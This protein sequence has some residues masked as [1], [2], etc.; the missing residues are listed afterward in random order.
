MTVCDTVAESDLPDRTGAAGVIAEAAVSR[1]TAKYVAI[2][3]KHFVLLS[4][5]RNYGPFCAERH[6]SLSRKLA[7]E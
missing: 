3:Q 6:V 7:V 2:M 4:R 1:K 5:H